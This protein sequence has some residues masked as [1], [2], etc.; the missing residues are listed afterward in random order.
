MALPDNA[1]G[2]IGS[3]GNGLLGGISQLLTNRSNR[4]IAQE[5]NEFNSNE[6]RLNREFQAQQAQIAR[7][8]QEEQYL[9][10]SSPSAMVQQYRD[11]GINPALMFGGSMQGSTGSSPSPSGSAASGSAIPMESP[12]FSGI[13]ADFLGLVKLRQD[14]AESKSREAANYAN[15][16]KS[17]SGIRVDNATIHK[18]AVDNEKTLSDIANNNKSV[19]SQVRFINGQLSKIAQDNKVSQKQIEEIDAKIRQMAHQNAL[20][21]QQ[22]ATLCAQQV[23]LE[24]QQEES[25]LRQNEILS[26]IRLNNANANVLSD[27]MF[28]QRFK[29]KYLYLYG[30]YPP[31]EAAIESSAKWTNKQ[32]KNFESY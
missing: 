3:L 24:F 2:M 22:K 19:E 1:F 4:K 30:S 25:Y 31:A 6:A 18:M 27:K 21:D 5:T 11:A 29:N 13:V 8:W 26:N 16:E 32:Q 7:D 20:T 15:A 12:N 14:I 17:Y 9:K 10:Y 28:E 23:L